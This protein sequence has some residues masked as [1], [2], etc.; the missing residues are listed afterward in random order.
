MYGAT[1]LGSCF[2]R[3]FNTLALYCYQSPCA[4]GVLSQPVRYRVNCVR[5]VTIHDSLRNTVSILSK[6][7]LKHFD[8]HHSLPLPCTIAISRIDRQLGLHHPLASFHDIS[9]A[10][11]VLSPWLRSRE[12]Q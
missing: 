10:R 12:R 1:S 11:R 9:A 6:P 4:G 8:R 3:D 5:I 7:L 2:L